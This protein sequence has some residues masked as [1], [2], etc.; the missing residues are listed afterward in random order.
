VLDRYA[1]SAATFTAVLVTISGF[2]RGLGKEELE[3]LHNFV[4][5]GD[6]EGAGYHLLRLGGLPGM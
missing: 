5:D 1:D 2:L 3:T 4:K 6:F